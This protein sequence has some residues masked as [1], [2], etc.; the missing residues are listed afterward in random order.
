VGIDGLI[1]AKNKAPFRPFVIRTGNGE[2]YPVDHPENI[3]FS[4]GRRFVSVWLDNE[5][6][7]IIDIA[8]ITE[9]VASPSGGRR[10]GKGKK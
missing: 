2:S 8:S 9:F 4:K 10:G 6:Q 1:A 7:A 3:S 5:D